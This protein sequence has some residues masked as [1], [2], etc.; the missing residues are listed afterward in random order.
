[1]ITILVDDRSF[2]FSENTLK[3]N[4]QFII[5]RIINDNSGGGNIVVPEIIEVIDK[6]TYRIDTSPE[7]FAEIA[8]VLRGK[9]DG[10]ET[11]ESLLFVNQT[12]QT[13]TK[14][15]IQ[16][17]TSIPTE[18]DKHNNEIILTPVQ[19]SLTG[20]SA[21]PAIT[22]TEPTQKS[23]FEKRPVISNFETRD[24]NGHDKNN[25][26]VNIDTNTAFST[27]LSTPK[28]GSI[29]STKSFDLM[30]MLDDPQTK[31]NTNTLKNTSLKLSP[32]KSSAILSG[33][34]SSSLPNALPKMYVLPSEISNASPSIFKK[35][36]SPNRKQ[37]SL[38]STAAENDKKYSLD[39]L[40]NINGGGD[41]NSTT[42]TDT[43][44]LRSDILR[45]NN[46][47]LTKEKSI[48]PQTNPIDNTKNISSD[49][50][51]EVSTNDN[52]ESDF[53]D[54]IKNNGKRSDQ[55]GFGI[56][57]EK[58]AEHSG[59]S[60]NSDNNNNINDVDSRKSDSK[61]QHKKRIF[62]A[63]KIELNTSDQF[64]PLLVMPVLQKV[65]DKN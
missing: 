8:R 41:L 60:E 28:Y 22:E 56:K 27:T 21:T 39:D 16:E 5:T 36:D 45:T 57:T 65:S 19:T 37:I 9:Y 51:T 11:L 3:K 46:Q 64:Q 40:I 58:Y 2:I 62:R 25:S 61:S 20:G 23:I 48:K 24:W 55:K 42:H 38:V 29:N 26:P 6:K 13:S 49:L 12:S 32:K 34:L 30:K 33:I 35:P 7:F 52:I 59:N 14:T 50:H 4:P 43:F 1:M 44:S 17:S 15:M 18:K 53:F 63:R 10:L 47:I 54:L 31:T